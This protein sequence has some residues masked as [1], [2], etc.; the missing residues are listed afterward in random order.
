LPRA[1]ADHAFD[2]GEPFDTCEKLVVRL[3]R[4]ALSPLHRRDRAVGE[5]DLE[6]HRTSPAMRAAQ[7]QNLRHGRRCDIAAAQADHDL[8]RVLPAGLLDRDNAGRA[9]ARCLATPIDGAF[10]EHDGVR[11]E[12]E[13]YRRL[14]I[15]KDDDL[16]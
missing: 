15:G 10:D 3:D 2:A 1:V 5:L 4:R 9:D 6:V 12:H 16:D 13:Q 14:L 11:L 8:A 7:L